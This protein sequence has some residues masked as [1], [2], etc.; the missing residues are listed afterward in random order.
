MSSVTAQ[1]WALS[2]AVAA[3][4]F[5][6]C[7]GSQA[8]FEPV[9]RGQ[10]R[11]ARIQGPCVYLLGTVEESD[12][13][14]VRI[15]APNC[16]FYINA[17][18]NMSYSTIK[19]AKI[20]Y[21]GA[22]PNEMGARFPEATPAPGPVVS[23]PCPTIR[24]CEYLTNHP[25]VTSGCSN[26]F[27]NESGQ[28]IGGA[29]QVTCFSNLTITGRNETVCGLIEVTGSQ[30][31]FQGSSTSSCSSGVTFAM[32]GN[33]DDTNFSG[34]NLT[35]APPK[36]GKYK[37]VLFYRLKSQ[38]AG[39][40]FSTCTCNFAGILYFPTTAVDYSGTGSNYQL[41]IFGQVN[42]STDARLRL[43]NPP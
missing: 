8:P 25:P 26:G 12:L 28:T 23:D 24:G 34:A 30:L 17:S 31:H 3:A 14:H 15:A 1:R 13:S 38:S 22:P 39:V 29:G 6:G 10:A 40:D 43:G 16:Y 37:G 27:F 32:S 2:I 33:T 18:A 11:L 35:L 36:V 20:L 5:G 21:A 42:F 7:A 9:A 41:L 19:A 4:L